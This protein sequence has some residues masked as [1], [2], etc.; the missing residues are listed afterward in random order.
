[1]QSVSF[2]Q[3]RNH[4]LRQDHKAV[5]GFRTSFMRM[6]KKK[7]GWRLG[8]IGIRWRNMLAQFS[9]DHQLLANVHCVVWV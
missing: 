3:L 1:M 2:R 8:A 7:D 9:D 5:A 4:A 6:K